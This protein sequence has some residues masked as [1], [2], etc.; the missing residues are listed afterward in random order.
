M[1]KM[2]HKIRINILHCEWKNGANASYQVDYRNESVQSFVKRLN[3]LLSRISGKKKEHFNTY[4]LKDNNGYICDETSSVLDALPSYIGYYSNE[5][6]FSIDVG[7]IEEVIPWEMLMR[8]CQN[9]YNLANVKNEP[10]REFLSGQYNASR[11]FEL[12][13]D[14]DKGKEKI[15]EDEYSNNLVAPVSPVLPK[16]ETQDQMLKNLIKQHTDRTEVT[17]TMFS[18]YIQPNILWNTKAM[19]IHIY[20]TKFEIDVLSFDV[21]NIKR[22]YTKMFKATL[23]ISDLAGTK[24]IACGVGYTKQ[25]AENVAAGVALYKLGKLDKQKDN[26]IFDEF[27]QFTAVHKENNGTLPKIELSEVENGNYL[28][29]MQYNGS[30]LVGFGCSPHDAKLS[31]ARTYLEYS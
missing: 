4:V 29:E 7:E 27:D 31:L 19:L 8:N 14:D 18:K 5:L 1:L 20:Q 28:A 16:T 10:A 9:E 17:A 11:K 30:R 23:D 6:P 15:K 22:S 21:C 3:S 2:E 12:K 13:A 24:S 26:K 25:E